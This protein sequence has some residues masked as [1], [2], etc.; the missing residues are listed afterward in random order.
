MH[1][2]QIR[3]ARC[4]PG[5]AIV[6]IA[7]ASIAVT[8]HQAMAP[9]AQGVVRVKPDDV[10]FAGG[11]NMQTVVIS[12][13]PTKPGLYVIRNLFPPGVMS[14]PHFHNQDRL[15]TVIKGTWW[16][17]TGPDGDIYNPDKTKPNPVGSFMKHPAG[18]H[19]YDGAKA[20]ECVVQIIGMGPVTT[21]DILPGTAPRMPAFERPGR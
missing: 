7:L 12:G 4:Q 10:K 18:L 14:R 5:C 3:L 17:A 19:H 2:R 9:D 21:T 16:T 11:P 13:D 8:A 1:L 15:V 6:A 20:E